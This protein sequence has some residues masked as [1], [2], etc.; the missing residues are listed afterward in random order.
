MN[1]ALGFAFLLMS[2]TAFA[3]WSRLPKG[4]QINLCWPQ[5]IQSVH[6]D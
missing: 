4:V 3:R 5:G 6:I 2:A 1:K